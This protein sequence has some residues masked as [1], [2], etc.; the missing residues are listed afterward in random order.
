[1]EQTSQSR[2]AR[3]TILAVGT[4]SARPLFD[5]LQIYDQSLGADYPESHGSIVEE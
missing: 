4:F 1:M 2:A 5:A 3:N